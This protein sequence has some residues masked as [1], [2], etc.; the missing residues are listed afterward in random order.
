[1]ETM[2]KYRDHDR[3]EIEPWIPQGGKAKTVPLE[4]MLAWYDKQIA[5]GR[6]L[7]INPR[8]VADLIFL[9]REQWGAQI[10]TNLELQVELDSRALGLIPISLE[11]SSGD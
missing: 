11:H 2:K 3:T 8:F 4:E 7:S 1:M 6:H 9:I 10:I 5:L